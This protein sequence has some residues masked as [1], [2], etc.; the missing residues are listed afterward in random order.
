MQI[1]MQCPAGL[2]KLEAVHHRLEGLGCRGRE[3]A[4][5][6]FAADNGISIEGISHFPA[7]RSGD[8][9]LNHLRGISPT[10]ILLRRLGKRE[11]IFDVG[12]CDDV[13]DKNLI[14]IPVRGGS[15]CFLEADALTRQEVVAAMD[16][17]RSAWALIGHQEL[18][19]VGVGEI[20]IG[21]TVC[22]S[23]LLSALL[24]IPAQVL[25]G[26]GT[27]GYRVRGRKANMIEEALRFRNPDPTDA[28]DLLARFGGLEIAALT[29]FI[30]G[31][32]EA[33]LPLMLDGYVTA[34]AALLSSMIN[35]GVVE[36]LFCPSLAAE[37]GHS[38][39]LDKL[40][41]QPLFDLSLNY[42]EGLASVYGLFFAETTTAFYH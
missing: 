14:K 11:W 26:P 18:D 24:G 23:A 19:L 32:R 22:A 25:L 41:L 6:I 5:V 17:G 8:L 10:A 12:L 36:Y 21:N 30:G 42:G 13:I 9:V 29:G 35:T 38:I 27:A 33:G 4:L 20:G 31:A 39:V 15:K 37:P 40:N 16:M 34:V 7:L 3:W 2:G 28:L 1:A